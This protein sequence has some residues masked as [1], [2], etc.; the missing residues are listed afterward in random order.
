MMPHTRHLATAVLP[1]VLICAGVSC[2]TGDGRAIQQAKMA[3]QRGQAHVAYDYYAQAARERPRNSTA[4]AGIKRHAP[5]AANYWSLQAHQA[6]SEGRHAEAWTMAMRSLQIRSDQQSVIDLIQQLEQRQPTAI[7]GAQREW[8]RTGRVTIDSEATRELSTVDRET[9]LAQAESRR[10]R[11]EARVAERPPPTESRRR[12]PEDRRTT[13]TPE[14]TRRDADARA[15]MD[16]NGAASEF[17]VMHVLSRKDKRHPERRRLADGIYLKLKDVNGDRTVDVDL[18]DG[19]DRVQKIRDM[20]VGQS[21]LFRGR[22]G[23]W[24][25]FTLLDAKTNSETIR[26]GVMP[27]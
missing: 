15:S 9:A 8:Q 21:K 10:S 14:R 23:R 1:M 22:S 11:D 25:R 20:R 19:N 12:E 26:I 16:A 18:D 24:Y 2:T 3:E 13:A 6:A 27:G 7:A 5:A 4:A 17:V